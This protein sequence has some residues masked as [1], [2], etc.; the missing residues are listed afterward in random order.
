MSQ[1][2]LTEDG[3]RLIIDLK[4]A[5]SEFIYLILFNFYYCKK[6]IHVVY[7]KILRVEIKKQ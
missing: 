7:S 5:F 3:Q 4:Y 2:P 6:R 1:E